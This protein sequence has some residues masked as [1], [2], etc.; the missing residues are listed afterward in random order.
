M[1][2]RRAWQILILC[3]LGTALPALTQ[4]NFYAVFPII[5]G[6]IGISTTLQANMMSI[7]AIT[8]TINKL[9]CGAIVDAYGAR[10]VWS[11]ALAICGV[12]LAVI[13]SA[14]EEFPWIVIICWVVWRTTKAFVWPAM[15]VTLS[16]HL[17]GPMFSTAFGIL[18]TSSRVGAVLGGFLASTCLGWTAGWRKAVQITAAASFVMAIALTLLLAPAKKIP[19]AAKDTNP[20]NADSNFATDTSI[21]NRNTDSE[22]GENKRQ[23]RLMEVLAVALSSPRF[24]LFLTF[25]ALAFPA[26]SLQDLFPSYFVAQG[27]SAADAARV[28]SGWPAGMAL[29][30][31]LAGWFAGRSPKAAAAVIGIGMGISGALMF[32]LSQLDLG[33]S[34]PAE[35]VRIQRVAQ[36]VLCAMGF[37]FA[38]ALYLPPATF[39]STFGGAHSKALIVSLNDFTGNMSTALFTIAIPQLVARVGWG[40][41]IVLHAI[42]VVLSAVIISYLQWWQIVKPVEALVVR[43]AVEKKAESSKKDQ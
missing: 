7:C 33:A 18:S 22:S 27:M 39:T 36:A 41:V 15:V 14:S 21:K 9:I 13:A 20:A 37:C 2:T 30:L 28:S 19:N 11:S 38:P 24:L 42:L 26:F 10:T 6:D 17:K 35:A 34:S 32:L 31:P 4:A 23:P 25:A 3:Y 43:P 12:V 1:F 40:G 5:K 29:S 16:T 8:N